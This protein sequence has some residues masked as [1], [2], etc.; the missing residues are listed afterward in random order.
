MTLTGI[1]GVTGTINLISDPSAAVEPEGW[2]L[3]GPESA[4]GG[5]GAGHPKFATFRVVKAVDSLSPELLKAMRL[6]DRFTVATITLFV[7]GTTTP[8]TTYE[9]KDV[10]T[11]GYRLRGGPVPI[12]ELGLD[13]SAI[14]QTI[15]VAGGEP[16]VGCWSLQENKAC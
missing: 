14:K 9:L 1:P 2:G 7:P 3:I 5:G 13:F 8:A 10:G 15:P 6:G 12:E 16:K 11:G 4:G